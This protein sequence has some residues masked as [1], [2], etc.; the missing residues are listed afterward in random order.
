MMYFYNPSCRLCTKTNEVV[1]LAEKKYEG[2]MSHQR[3]NISDPEVGMD[4]V[5]YMFELMD[6]MHVPEE[7]NITLIVFLGILEYD[8]EGP[9]FTPKRVLVEGDEIIAKLDAEA[10]DFLAKEGKGEMTPVAF[11]PAS[12]FSSSSALA[13][14]AP[15]DAPVRPRVRRSNTS[16]ETAAAAIESRADAKLR[17]GAIS[18][19]A[20]ADSVNPCAFATIIIL[21]AMMSSAKRTK[22]E[23]IAVCLSFTAAVFVTY[24][25][26]GLFLYKV[27]AMI[28]QG[29]GWFLIVADVIYYIAFLLCVVFG[30]LSLWDAYKMFSGRATEEM[31]LQLPKAFKK[32]INVAMAK[33]VRARWLVVGVFIA[34]VTVSFFEAACTGQV[35]LPTIISL[36]KISFWHSM[37]LLLW[38]NFLF[39]VPLLLIFALVLYGV[40]STQ[41]TRF[42]K[43][44]VAWIRLALGLVFV[45]MGIIIW[46]EMYWPP[47]Y[48]GAPTAVTTMRQ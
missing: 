9:L 27:I 29:G 48:R 1:A 11:A 45:L 32:R 41:L 10:A 25:A 22:N 3:F 40:T 43:N 2:V 5:L 20:L 16:G 13:A 17:F 35:Y 18:L 46:H 21:V 14:A 24:L 38:Y 44:N 28:N 26:I 47:G 34:G 6:E 7:D 4:N 19:A 36:A 39:I 31:T 23:I 33:G 42:F 12:F 8:D 37:A 15:A 30:L